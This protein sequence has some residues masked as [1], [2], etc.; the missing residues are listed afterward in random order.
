MPGVYSRVRQL[1]TGLN[2]KNDSELYQIVFDTAAAGIVTTDSDGLIQSCNRAFSTMFGYEYEELLGH[3]IAILM[4]GAH[5]E[6]HQQYIERYLAGFSAASVMGRGREVPARRRNGEQFLIHLTVSEMRVAGER[7][8]MAIVHDLSER[9][10]SPDQQLDRVWLGHVLD[11]TPAALTVK[12]VNG[13]Y[14]LLNER[15]ERMLRTNSRT[16]VGKTDADIFPAQWASIQQRSDQEILSATDARIFVEPFSYSGQPGDEVSFLCSKNLLRDSGGNAIGIV[17]LMVD[18]SA[19][20]A[21]NSP[22]QT[23]EVQLL[24]AL[25]QPLALLSASGDLLQ[26]NQ[27][28]AHRFGMS[29][30]SVQGCNIR[31]LESDSISQQLLP[32]LAGA[33]Q[34]ETVITEGG[35]CYHVYPY[36]WQQQPLYV[37][38]LEVVADNAPAILSEQPAYDLDFIGS[39]SHELR[40]PLNAVIGFS[41]LLKDE[42]QDDSQREAVQ[43]IEEAGQHLTALVD[44]ILDLVKVQG[45]E[46]PLLQEAVSVQSVLRESVELVRPQL[47]QRG[48]GLSLG[49]SLHEPWVLA[50]RLRVKQIL[51]NLLSNAVKYN[52]EQGA[53][54]VLIEGGDG[55]HIRIGVAD[56]GPGIEPGKMAQLFTPFNRLGAEQQGIPGTG[57][58]LVISQKLA[59]RMGGDLSVESEAGKGT[60]FWLSLPAASPM[61]SF[62]PDAPAP[63]H[64]ATDD[65]QCRVLY[66][67]DNHASARCV[68]LGLRHRDKVS[69]QIA[70]TGNEGLNLAQ[71]QTPDVILLD[72]RLPDIHGLEVLKKLREMPELAEARIYGVSAEALPDQVELACNGGLDGYMT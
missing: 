2:L 63:R 23:S 8:F 44:Q 32:L 27:A 6:H 46:L 30:R 42:L 15:A 10:P 19:L 56:T 49:G 35:C 4:A 72:M 68:E 43:L 40:T 34:T 62:V 50:D 48:I 51:L 52:R 26:A 55:A 29:R 28:Y 33:P 57:L 7:G 71:S 67:E 24:D 61:Y 36:S 45:R 41:Q 13:R 22:I 66:I 69:L 60:T 12:D 5:A 65:D 37:L 31:L 16:A 1:M 20:P 9:V 47:Q 70:S 11:Q 64:D 39:L 53:V 14:L 54:R 17:S 59:R 25:P 38:M 58:G 21:I 18:I 3:N